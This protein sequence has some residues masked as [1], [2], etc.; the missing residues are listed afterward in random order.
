VL[1]RLAR[2]PSFHPKNNYF[3]LLQTN[4][5]KNLS[6]KGWEYPYLVDRETLP[7]NL[8]FSFDFER[9][10]IIAVWTF[11]FYQILIPPWIFP[12]KLHG[13]KARKDIMI[14]KATESA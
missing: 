1:L 2:T 3:N 7:K 14:K 12:T 9:N 6:I 8:F 11:D 5:I 13:I 4:L 10:G